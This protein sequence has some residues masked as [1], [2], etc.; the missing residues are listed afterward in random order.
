MSIEPR[1]PASSDEEIIH[2]EWRDVASERSEEER[3]ARIE[4]EFRTGFEKLAGV[5]PAVCVFGSA[6]TRP[7]DSEY[8]LA[9]EAGRAIGEAGFAVITGE[10]ARDDGGGQPRRP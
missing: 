4:R 6:R 9:R 10:R 5:G 3:L 2:A 1:T 7:G 8:E